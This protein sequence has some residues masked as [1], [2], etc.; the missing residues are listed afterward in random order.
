M[1]AA[2]K[3]EIYFVVIGAQH[4]SISNAGTLSFLLSRSYITLAKNVLLFLH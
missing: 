3:G 2:E 1:I 4:H